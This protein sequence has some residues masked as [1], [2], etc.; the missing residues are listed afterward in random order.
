MSHV[1]KHETEA[2]VL[3]TK[4]AARTCD[5][6]ARLIYS[7]FGS[8]L[9]PSAVRARLAVGHAALPPAGTSRKHL[10]LGSKPTAAVNAMN[11]RTALCESGHAGTS[12]VVCRAE[13]ALF[14]MFTQ[15]KQPPLLYKTHVSGR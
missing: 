11:D 12:V 13:G 14:C 4:I 2:L 5:A 1:W 8:Q 3:S 6:S 7:S 10:A 9:N 15:A